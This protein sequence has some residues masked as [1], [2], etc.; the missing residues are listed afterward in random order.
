MYTKFCG[1]FLLAMLHALLTFYAFSCVVLCVYL[2][3]SLACDGIRVLFPTTSTTAAAY[4][5]PIVLYLLISNNDL[6]VYY[7]CVFCARVAE[8]GLCH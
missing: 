4:A 8:R 7:V 3:C 5:L 2:Y 1:E 6:H